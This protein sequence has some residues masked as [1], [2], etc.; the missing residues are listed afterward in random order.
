LSNLPKEVLVIDD[1]STVGQSVLGPLN[2]YS[3]AISNAQELETAIYQ[4]NHQEFDV[5]MV[6]L[7]YEALHGL[8]LIQKFRN[9]DDPEKRATGFILMSGK[10][11]KLSDDN[12]LK[13]LMDLDV[14]VKPFSVVHLLPYLS[15]ALA[16]KKKQVVFERLRKAALEKV[17]AGKIGEAIDEV[18]KRLKEFGSKGIILM[19]ELYEKSG[20]LEEA[21]QFITPFTIK[22][23][24]NIPYVNTRG[25]LLMLL[26]RF[27]EAKPMLEKAQENS[28]HNLARLADLGNMY[29][30]LNE[31]EKAVSSMRNLLQL[32]PENPDIKFEM[33]KKLEDSGHQVHAQKFCQETTTPKDV[34]RYYN[35]KGVELSRAGDI[36]GAIREYERAIKFFPTSKDNYRIFYN[37]GLAQIKFKTRS[38]YKSAA[39]NLQRCLDLMPD[40]EKARN[41]LDNITR[42]LTKDDKDL[43]KGKEVK[44]EKEIKTETDVKETKDPKDAKETKDIKAAS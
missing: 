13:E 32:T 3:V 34:V 30:G 21:L 33:F 15:R 7:E 20:G 17:A 16:G 11:R 41:T 29:I 28:P 8:A 18:K 40:F 23:P 24:G 2:A 37:I 42:I 38:A 44:P 12:L 39:M 6:E 4:F 35:N 14:I 25:R 27:D 26:G 36:E 31:P 9:H 22:D 43:E 19:C 1:D 5:V 10:S